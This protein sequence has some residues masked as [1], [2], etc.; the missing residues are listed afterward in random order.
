MEG[1]L[2]FTSWNSTNPIFILEMCREDPECIH[3]LL[4]LMSTIMPLMQTQ[5]QSLSP[6]PS[7]CFLR[8]HLSL[9]QFLFRQVTGKCLAICIWSYF[10]FSF[11]FPSFKSTLTFKKK[12]LTCGCITSS[13]DMRNKRVNAYSASNL[14]LSFQ[15]LFRRSLWSDINNVK[16]VDSTG[17]QSLSCN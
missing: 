11:A 17:S 4:S 12:K 10:H 2:A 14:S 1:S 15:Y 9:Y 7:G 6:D 13:F 8:Y 16:S 5:T 3:Q